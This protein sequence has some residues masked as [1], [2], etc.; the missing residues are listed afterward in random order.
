MGFFIRANSELLNFQYCIRLKMSVNQAKIISKLESLTNTQK[1]EFFFNFLEAFNFPKATIQRLREPNGGAKNV[2]LNPQDGELA[3]KQSIYFK[4]VAQGVNLQA[5]TLDLL[6]EEA[7][8]KNKIRFI[9]TTDFNDIYAYDTLYEDG[10]DCSFENLV[11]NYHFF[12]PLVKIERSTSYQ[13]STADVKASEKMGK[14]FDAIKQENNLSSADDVYALNSFMARLLFCYF[15]EDTGIFPENLFTQTIENLSDADG[16]N[17]N[18]LLDTMFSTMNEKIGSPARKSV[19]FK[20]NE[21]PYV[22]GGLFAEK[23]QTPRLNG[24]IRRVMIECG[25]LDWSEI[26]PDI[27]GSMFQAVVEPEHRHSHG[28][29]Y[30]SVPNIMRVI[31]PLF[32]G[33]L[34]EELESIKKITSTKSKINALHNFRSRLG[35][36]KV[37]DFACGSGNFLIIA[38]KELR[39]IEME[40]FKE[41]QR[42]SPNSPLFYSEISLEQ[43]YGIE[44]DGFAHHIAILA[45]WLAEHQMNMEFKAEFGD[46]TPTLPLKRSSTIIHGDSLMLNWEEIM[47]RNSRDDEVY[48]IGNPPFLGFRGRTPEQNEA[49]ENVFK[50]FKKAKLLDFVTGWFWKGANYIKNSNAKL[51]LVATNSICQGD[52]V[53]TLWPKIFD[54]GCSIHFAHQSFP[55]KNNARQNA[56]V[57][58]IIVGLSCQ[59]EP[60]KFIYSENSNGQPI[61]T[62]VNNISPYLTAGSNIAVSSNENPLCNAKKMLFGNMA[63]DGGHLFLSTNEKNTALREF[64]EL[65][66]YIKKALGAEEFI[67]G[68]ERWCLWLP[69]APSEILENVF[70]QQK[71]LKTLE[72]RKKSKNPRA[73]IFA[74]T[75]HLFQQISQTKSEDFLLIPIHT[76]E[77][78][79]YIPIGFFDSQNIATNSCQ[80]IADATL[81]DFAIMTSI[82]HNEWMQTI[83]GR[84]KSDYRYSTTLVYNNFVW[85]KA[86]AKQ[87]QEVE[88]LAQ[89]ILDI[90]DTHFDMT[91]GQMYH[92][93]TMPQDLKDAHHTLDLAVDALYRTKPFED[94]NDRIEHLFA[95]Y[96]QAIAAESNLKG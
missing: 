96:E 41:I 4:P 81:Y 72:V 95:L 83:A 45:M 76:S 8:N 58:V 1:T 2:A 13:D 79:T 49:V 25:H 50:G 66:P 94:A 86:S 92:P 93:D 17:L 23:L 89:D 35:K 82:I 28:Q 85:P 59:K 57:H 53:A 42:S 46:C 74:A 52:Q 10:L 24:R 71:V 73:E 87:K 39:R 65:K 36:I 90:R 22:N 5:I 77:N 55:W 47:P 9:I 91:L 29:H 21:F 37:A 19:N 38:Y 6:K 15:A 75:P 54:L 31:E 48:I 44:I 88:K 32:I 27:F 18:E 3:I 12:L 60:V 34:K 62:I 84:L 7:I 69:D 56:A 80:I 64:P 33:P 67:N 63:A 61:K 51:A 43:F 68:K 78:R 26:N 11:H 40:V 20:I 70:V 14:L 30:T 16:S